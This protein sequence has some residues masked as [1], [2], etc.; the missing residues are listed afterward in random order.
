MRTT[1]PRPFV[2]RTPTSYGQARSISSAGYA[3]E[4]SSEAQVRAL[5]ARANI[6]PAEMSDEDLER[7]GALA[8]KLGDTQLRSHVFGARS[9]AAFERHCFHEAAAWSER[10]LA[11]LSD[12][13]D[14]DQL[15]EAYES[16][17]PAALAVGRVG[18][19]R[20]LTGLH[21]DLSQRLSPHHQLH[22]FAVARDRRRSG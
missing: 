6:E 3:P 14:P 9:G 2:P 8:E 22:D 15:C 12:V 5:V 16:G 20:R 21:R 11:L 4:Q 13:D 17:V 19:A 7:V 1:S 18:E 10:R